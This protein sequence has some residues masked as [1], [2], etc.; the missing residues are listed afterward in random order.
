YNQYRRSID[1]GNTWS[2]VNYSSS[3]GA[4]INP[5]DYDSRAKK[6]YCAASN[7]QI[8]RWENPTSG[9]TFTPMTISGLGG[10]ATHIT[11]SPYTP[12]RVFVGS[13]SGALKR[14]DDANGAGYTVTKINHG[15]PGA[16][17]S[18]IAPG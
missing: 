15:T 9:N 8:L 3:I 4:F 6:M 14:I 10:R 12:N 11:V 13:S 17:V 7:D 5:T 2:S 18:C 1:G 16:N